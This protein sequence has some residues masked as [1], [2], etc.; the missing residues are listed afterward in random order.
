MPPHHPHLL[1]SLPA[2]STPSTQPASYSKKPGSLTLFRG[3]LPLCVYSQISSFSPTL[4][5][6]SC[7]I[8]PLLPFSPQYALLSNIL[9]NFADL[10]CL[11]PVYLHQKVS[12]TVPGIF[13]FF[14]NWCHPIAGRQQLM[15]V[16]SSLLNNFKKKKKEVIQGLTLRY[17]SD[18]CA[19]FFI[20]CQFLK[21]KESLVHF[22]NSTHVLQ[23]V[24]FY[25]ILAALCV[26]IVE[27]L[28]STECPKN[29]YS[30]SPK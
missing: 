29:N 16:V 8:P 4:F 6:H 24:F 20:P 22:Q 3:S 12:S 10:F 28:L 25:V 14:L 21:V 30:S 17:Y 9:Y 7:Q 27:C 11:L 15:V 19:A 26:V 18:D 1:C 23:Y 13:V 2:H 5:S